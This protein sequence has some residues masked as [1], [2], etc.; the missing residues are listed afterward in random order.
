MVSYAVTDLIQVD[1]YTPSQVEKGI[2]LIVLGFFFAATV[3]IQPL[4]LITLPPLLIITWKAL[5]KNTV[6]P[7]EQSYIQ[8]LQGDK[9]IMHYGILL[10]IPLV[11]TVIYACALSLSIL[12]P[13]NIIVYILLTPLGFACYI[14]AILKIVKVKNI[15]RSP[16]LERF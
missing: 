6:P 7:S 13:T 9:N 12:L 8:L 10:C 11:T 5:R 1:S 3:W 15:G 4:A 16:C 2:V 14:L